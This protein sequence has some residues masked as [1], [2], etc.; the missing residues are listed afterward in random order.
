ML[1]RG[2]GPGISPDPWLYETYIYDRSIYIKARIYGAHSFILHC[3]CNT[4]HCNVF[5]ICLLCFAWGLKPRPAYLNWRGFF[6]R[7][8]VRLERLNSFLRPAFGLMAMW[9]SAEA[10]RGWRFP[11]RS[12]VWTGARLRTGLGFY[13]FKERVC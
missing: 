5:I 1:E 8:F 10:V 11:N 7:K 9:P 2:V 12:T 13:A 6:K 4:L 3:I